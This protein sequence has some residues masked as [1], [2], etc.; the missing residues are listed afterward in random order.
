MYIKNLTLTINFVVF[1]AN[2]L[3]FWEHN[4]VKQDVTSDEVRKS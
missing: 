2:E 1:L 3:I 4:D